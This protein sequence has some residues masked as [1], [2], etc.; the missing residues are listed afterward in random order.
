MSRLYF[1]KPLRR[2]TPFGGLSRS[3]LMSRVGSLGNATTELRMVRLLREASLGG[4]RRRYPLDGQPDFV[5]P[6]QRIAMF[7]DGCFWHGHDCG[8]NLRPRRNAAFWNEKVRRNRQRDK[9][10]T[11]NLRVSGWTVIRFWECQLTSAAESC[12]RRI[13]TALARSTKKEKN[14]S[15]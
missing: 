8:R 1:Q 2:R 9:S 4:W 10:V 3:E 12:K 14:A 7:V 6:A 13:A 11:R 5:W 15:G